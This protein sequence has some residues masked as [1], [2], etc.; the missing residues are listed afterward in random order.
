MPRQMRAGISSP[1]LKLG[2]STMVTPV[3]P[4]IVAST[5]AHGAGLWRIKA[6]ITK[7]AAMKSGVV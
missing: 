4:A 1:S 3:K 5:S 2:C 7:L 6:R